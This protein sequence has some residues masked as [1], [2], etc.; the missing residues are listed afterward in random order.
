MQSQRP[1]LIGL[2]TLAA[3]LAANL[4][5]AATP[6][7]SDVGTHVVRYSDLDLSRPEDAHTLYVRIQKAARFVCADYAG[8]A[9]HSLV[10]YNRCVHRAVDDGVAKVRAAQPRLYAQF[11]K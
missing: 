6:M 11:G 10:A 9:L 5:A 8:G 1:L 3:A 4:A 2:T 7:D